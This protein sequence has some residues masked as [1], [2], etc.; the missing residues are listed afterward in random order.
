[1]TEPTSYYVQIDQMDDTRVEFASGRHGTRASMR[2]EDWEAVGR[3]SEVTII[4][5]GWEA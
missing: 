5:K 3:P 2:R 4:T 1:M